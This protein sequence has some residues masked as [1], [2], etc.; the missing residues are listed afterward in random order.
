MNQGFKP[1]RPHRSQWPARTAVAILAWFLPGVN[2]PSLRSDPLVVLPSRHHLDRATRRHVA[3]QRHVDRDNGM[4]RISVDHAL[5]RRPRA[6]R[7]SPRSRGSSPPRRRAAV[8]ARTPSVNTPVGDCPDR[9]SRDRPELRARRRPAQTVPTS[10][11]VTYRAAA[12]HPLR[13]VLS[14]DGSD[15]SNH[16]PRGL[17][18]QHRLVRRARDGHRHARDSSPPA[19]CSASSRRSAGAARPGRASSSSSCT[20]TCRCSSSCSSPST[21]S[22][23]SSTRSRR[24]AG[25]TWSCRSSPP[26]GRSGS[27][28]ARSRS[29]C[30]SRSSS[31]ASSATVSATPRGASVHW[32]AY[33]CWPV[34]VLHGFGTGSDTTSALVLVF[35]AVCVVSVLVAGGLC[36]STAGLRDRV[37]G[38]VRWV[39]A[40][41]ASSLPALLVAWLVSGPLAA[42]WAAQGRDAGQRPRRR[43]PARPLRFH[44]GSTDSGSP[45]R[46]TTT[47]PRRA[48]PSPPPAST[49]PPHGQRQRRPSRSDGARRRLADRPARRR[50]ER[51][52]S[53]SRSPAHPLAGGGV[54]MRSGTVTLSDGTHSYQGAIVGLAGLADRRRR[55]P[56]PAA[57]RGSRS[58]DVTV[59]R[60]AARAPCAPT[61]TS[62]PVGPPGRGDD[63]GQDHGDDRISAPA[64]L[65]RLL[66]PSP[67]NLGEH[68]ARVRAAPRAAQAHAE[69][70]ECIAMVER[71]GLRGRGGGWLPDRAQAAA[72]SPTV[73]AIRSSWPTAPKVS[74]PAART[75]SLLRHSPHLVIDGAVVAAR[76]VGAEEIH[77]VVDRHDRRRACVRSTRAL[78]DAS[79][80]DAAPRS[81]GRSTSSRR[82]TSRG[83]ES[84]VVHFLNGGEAKPV[85][86][87]PR[88]VRARG[89]R[90]R[91]ARAERRDA[92]QPRA[93][94][95]LRPRVVRVGRHHRRARVG[96]HDRRSARSRRPGV[97]EFALGTPFTTRDRDAPAVRPNRSAPCWWVDTSAPGSTFR[98]LSNWCSRTVC[99]SRAGATLGCGV[100]AALPAL[101]CGIVET[102]RVR[103]LPRRSESAGQCGPCVHGLAAIATALEALAA[104]RAPRGTVATVERWLGD[105][106]GRGACHLPDAVVGFV[107]SSLAVF[108]DDYVLHERKGPCSAVGHLP[109]L[110]LPNPATRDRSWR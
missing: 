93:R 60:P 73:V 72:P 87:P 12:S 43:R 64:G 17:R 65:P 78:R 10:P 20:A 42:G 45:P 33:A 88:P 46:P 41:V 23:S 89:A 3:P 39:S 59:A 55:C 21:W 90:S 50:S 29:T 63:G 105:V 44:I 7:S 98:P 49:P 103:A 56:D 16:R 52:R 96:P 79:A 61:C 4:R 102:A 67:A 40:L 74:P 85:S 30:C 35:T 84:A 1:T 14:R 11:P 83:E 38:R 36:A 109:V 19:C 101:S 28:W 100:V 110:P 80:R 68:V 47:R 97:F 94:R 27:G 108:A 31:P 2:P 75:T 81:P 48:A 62:H 91:H 57:P 13:R 92:G 34:A 107:R 24:S 95:A 9:A 58:I 86:V 69:R 8:R 71:S 82:A 106:A 70:A 26:T 99:C 104:G 54:S 53:T 32:L 51:N 6:S 76:A 66:A 18:R 37:R 77:F 25:S 5:A 15:A 22:P